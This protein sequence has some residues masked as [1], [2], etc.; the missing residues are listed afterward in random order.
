MGFSQC[1]MKIAQVYCNKNVL[2]SP[3]CTNT[4]LRFHDNVRAPCDIIL[5]S[6][7]FY[8]NILK[9]LCSVVQYCMVLSWC[10]T[11]LA[12][13]SDNIVQSHRSLHFN[14]AWPVLNMYMKNHQNCVKSVQELCEILQE[15]HE[16]LQGCENSVISH[17]NCCTQCPSISKHPTISCKH[18]ATSWFSCRWI[19][20]MF[21]NTLISHVKKNLC[22]NHPIIAWRHLKVIVRARPHWT[23][24]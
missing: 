2:E 9:I 5:P 11:W 13:V 1:H 17:Y 24:V 22:E 19:F 23:C 7:E 3:I 16:I 10:C 21:K 18:L 8:M 12:Q 14:I 6:C 4:R 15:L 20:Y